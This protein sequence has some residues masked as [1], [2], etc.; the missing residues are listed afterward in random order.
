MIEKLPNK[1]SSKGKAVLII[2]L[3]LVILLI[4]FSGGY[5]TGVWDQARL[6]PRQAIMRI[7]NASDE[8]VEDESIDFKLYWKI[9]DEIN[10]N[11]Y[12]QPVD[13][14]KMFYGSLMGLTASLQ[15]PYSVFLD[16]EL[17]EE[18]SDEMNGS[19]EGIGAEVGIRDDAI[20]IIAPL[21][22]SP[23]EKAGLRAGDIVLKIDDTDTIN[24]SL[25]QA[26]K[27]IRGEKG[28]PVILTVIGM[29]EEEIRE[30]E[31]IRDVIQIDSVK[32]EIINTS[33]GKIGY[34]E[35]IHFS[36]DTEGLFNQAVNEILLEHPDGLIID[37]RNNPG[38]YLDSS[39]N[40]SSK[41]IEDKPVVYEEFSDG[42]KKE[43]NAKGSPQLKG[44]KTVILINEGSASASEIIAGALKDYK[45]ATLVG[46]TTFGKGSVQDY[47]TFSDGSSLK[48]TIANWLTPNLQNINEVGISPDIEVD[49]TLED[50]EA[51]IDPQLE[52]AKE[53]I[54]NE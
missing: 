49:R 26:I 29:E 18:F 13:D 30:I 19:F 41:W 46:K 32:W 52:K 23:A 4:G 53:L 28:T 1:K 33:E 45:I 24:M 21:P 43:Y 3:I 31:I 20:T 6:S 12:K 42:S 25:D 16:P 37:L 7:I 5:I 44:M 11:Y 15:D 9:W 39:I 54:I 50:I 38:G 36:A 48:L 47:K 51:D 10:E 14:K 35:I 40:I 2:F 27:L 17:T 22:E 8:K 34:I